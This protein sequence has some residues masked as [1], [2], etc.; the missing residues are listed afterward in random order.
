[1]FHKIMVPIDLAHAD[2]MARAVGVATQLARQWSAPI[3]FVGATASTP[4]PVA[5]NPAEYALKLGDYAGRIAADNGVATDSLALTLKD[6]AV[7][8]DH[9]LLDAASD[10]GADLVVIASHIPGVAEYVW[11]SHGGR[12]AGHAKASVFVVRPD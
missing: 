1:M 4:G 7:E 8:L 6:P 9:A 5:H 3:T 12:L 2:R 10:L 11:P